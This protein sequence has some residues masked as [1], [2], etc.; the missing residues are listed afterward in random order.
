[1]TIMRTTNNFFQQETNDLKTWIQILQGL[2]YSSGLESLHADLLF[3]QL[4]KEI[5]RISK[6]LRLLFEDIDSV[7]DADP[8]PS[9]LNHLK[10]EESTH[11][12]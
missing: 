1:M 5:D 6:D 10:E 9:F 4:Y 2:L 3:R 11:D 8:F 7:I 12:N